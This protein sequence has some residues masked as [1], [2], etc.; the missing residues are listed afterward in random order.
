MPAKSGSVPSPSFV[1]VSQF[2]VRLNPVTICEVGI[3]Q[4]ATFYAR[5]I[6]SVPS[7][8]FVEVSQ[9][10]TRLNLD[11]VRAGLNL[12]TVRE[13]GIV[14]VTTFRAREIGSV[15]SPSF[16]EV[17]QFPTGL[18]AD[19][20]R[21]VGIVQGTTFRA[22]A[23]LNPG[24]IREVGIVQGTAFHA[25]E[26]RLVLPRKMKPLSTAP[27]RKSHRHSAGGFSDY[28]KSIFAYSGLSSASRGAALRGTSSRT[29]SLD[30]AGLSSK[31]FS[32][33]S[34]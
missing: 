23:G 16:V 29:C 18:N 11:T 14:Q 9:F 34:R 5:E 17:S 22:R 12:D 13:V 32:L 31:R 10:S 21:E 2:P 26:I 6:G 7:P 15:P 28:S 3:V 19:T 24:T 1:E 25:R 20:I 33:R 8:S 27:H 30:G 4:G